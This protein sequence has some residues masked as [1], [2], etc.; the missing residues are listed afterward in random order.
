[1]K[2]TRLALASIF[3]LF[4]LAGKAQTTTDTAKNPVLCFYISDSAQGKIASGWLYKATTYT[5]QF[6]P[7][8]RVPQDADSFVVKKVK[9]PTK[10]TYLQRKFILG[11]NWTYVTVPTVVEF[12]YPKPQ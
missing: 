10:I 9:V 8:Q 3:L 4:S 11:T 5:Y 6:D 1:M 2:T 12:V 7:Q